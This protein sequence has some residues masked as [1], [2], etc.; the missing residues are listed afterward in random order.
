MP[1]SPAKWRPPAGAL[2]AAITAA[3]RRDEREAVQWLLGQIRR[4]AALAGSTQALA[5]KLV[6]AVRAERSRASGVDAL[7]HEFSLVSRRGRGAD[8]PGR[9]AAAHSRR[10]Q[11]RDRLIRDKIG[12]GDWRAHVGRSPSLFV[13][14]A[15]WGLLITGKLVATQQRAGPG[16]AAQ[17][18]VCAR[19]ASR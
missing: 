1:P 11:P 14:A 19:A 9:G 12:R 5:Q 15:T 7:M 2:R 16:A 3:Y 4:D 10:G 8:V 13:N 17:R 6:Q 18:A